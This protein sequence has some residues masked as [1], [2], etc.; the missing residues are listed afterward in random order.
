[1]ALETFGTSGKL[2]RARISD[3]TYESLA[4]GREKWPAAL[5]VRLE[6]LLL[7]CDIQ[8]LAGRWARPDN[9][10]LRQ[11]SGAP[12]AHAGAYASALSAAGLESGIPNA[13]WCL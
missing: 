6:V 7:G 8:P 13:C 3:I 10:I 9:V 4:L 2:A 12:G 1:M 5:G 11:S